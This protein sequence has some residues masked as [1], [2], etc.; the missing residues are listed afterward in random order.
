MKV[1]SLKLKNFKKFHDL[2][3]D[4]TDPDT[5]LVRDLIVLIGPNGAGKSSILQAIAA[6][7]GTASGRIKRPHHLLWPGF[8]LGLAGDSWKF[9]TEIDLEL[10]FSQT[11][12][13][14]TRDF[15]GHLGK[16]DLQ[17]PGSFG[18]VNLKLVGD[19]LEAM[20]G[21]S[22]WFQ[23]RG[24]EYAK[25][26]VRLHPDGFNVFEKV[27]APFWYTEQRTSSSLTPEEYNNH[28]L[29]LTMD[30]LRDRLSKWTLQKMMRNGQQASSTRRDL[31]GDLE[32]AYRT[33]FPGHRFEGPIERGEIDQALAEPWY[34]LHDGT[35]SYEISE[36][37]GGE[38]AV[39]PILFDFANW[40]IN[41]SLILIDELELHLHPPMQQALL[42][43]LIR[44][45]KGHSEHIYDMVPEGSIIRLGQ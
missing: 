36:M 7:V 14:A 42:D 21:S 41:H 20:E 44:L 25:Q 10:S 3:L 9:P 40:K 33:V 45:G 23:F 6:M 31:L 28:N 2:T 34:F 39:F 27:G 26:V 5:G 15:F 17:E 4:F 19:R 37:S 24:R 11:E 12:I 1:R 13:E 22:A 16:T 38:R 35:R 18:R 32:K 43:A 30:K 8:D 29:E